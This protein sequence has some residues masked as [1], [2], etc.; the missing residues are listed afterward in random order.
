ME[1]VQLRKITDDNVEDI[2]ELRVAENQTN[3]VADNNWSLIQAYLT[4]ADG[5]PVFPFGIYADDTP[6]G[7]VMINFDDDWTGYE[8]DG[9]L[10]SDNYRFYEGKPFYYIWRFMID[11][12]HQGKGYGK[13]A[14]RRT[15]EFIRTRPCGEADYCVLSYEPENIVAKKL[16]T[17]MGFEEINGPGYYEEGDEVSAVLKL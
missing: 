8:R 14:M 12:K 3:F 2:L 4:L 13:E 9:W 11:E 15:L 5:E 7:F 16:Y 1:Q 10:S 6:V 17:G